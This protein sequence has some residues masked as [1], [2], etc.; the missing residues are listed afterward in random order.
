M[1]R[2][3]NNWNYSFIILC[4]EYYATLDGSQY[5]LSRFLKDLQLIIPIIEK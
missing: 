3:H 1:Y 2:V 4:I 5:N